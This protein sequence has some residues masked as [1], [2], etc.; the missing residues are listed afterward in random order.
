MMN[1]TTFSG[2]PQRPV[3]FYIEMFSEK[4]PKQGVGSRNFVTTQGT[5]GRG[6]PLHSLPTS[7]F[8]VPF[9]STHQLL[10]SPILDDPKPELSAQ[11]GV[12]NKRKRERKAILS[13]KPTKRK[14]QKKTPSTKVKEGKKTSSATPFPI[15]A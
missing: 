6:A 4:Y 2:P 9:S 11:V 1:T 7:S 10:L 13:P 8:S 12:Y 14:P 5:Q 15:L 3:S